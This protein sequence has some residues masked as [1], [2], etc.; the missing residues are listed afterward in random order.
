[1][2]LC[3]AT[4]HALSIPFNESFTHG[5]KE[6]AASDALVIRVVTEDGVVGHGEGLAR[7]YVTGETP[8]GLRQRIRDVLWP[9]LRG[10]NVPD[11][12]PVALLDVVGELLGSSEPTA[13][14]RRT[15]VIAHHAARC[16]VELALVDA[17]LRT[18]ERAL[19]DALPPRTDT[20]RYGG[21]VGLVD[22]AAAVRLA[23]RI[24]AL[25]LGDCKVKVGDAHSLDRVR[26]VRE[27]LGP[28]VALRV[29]ANGVWDLER[30][31]DE[32]GALTECGIEG[33]EEPLGR[34]RRHELP[35]LLARIDVP[36]ILDESLVTAED[37]HAVARFGADVVLDVRLSK[38]GGLGPS[39]AL[40]RLARDAGQDIV[41]GC[42]V[43]ETALLSA[44]GCHLAAHLAD[45]LR[46]EGSFG[47][48]LLAE[49]LAEPDVC[50]GAGG[51]AAPLPGPG[52]GVEVIAERLERYTIERE[53]L[54]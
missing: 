1:M 19:A 34:E 22:P 41:I 50:F 25:G 53:V 7:P 17:A 16:A 13:D 27:T 23:Q 2:R 29:D 14:E 4:L 35:E 21:V 11:V 9:A 54:R 49:D 36:V 8:A 42:Q 5:T 39:L 12:A 30:A 38:C 48:L 15:G 26:A 40:A 31:I 43:G 37:A 18:R 6:R 32:I 24:R 3:E 28:D 10:V 51:H 20:V 45:P 52:L 46:L 44:A 33:V 47:R